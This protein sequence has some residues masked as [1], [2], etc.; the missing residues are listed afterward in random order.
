MFGLLKSLPSLLQKVLFCV[1]FPVS[2]RNTRFLA[3]APLATVMAESYAR[4]KPFDGST[5]FAMWQ[6]KMKA[7]LIKEKCWRAVNE[8]YLPGT[9]DLTKKDL[10]QQAHSEIM[11]RISDEVARQV[12]D[13][14]TAATLWQALQDLFLT[15]SLPN[16]VALLSQ[17]FHYK[18][19]TNN[20]LPE[21]LDRF[22]KLTQ[23]ISRCGEDV[24]DLNKSVLLLNSLPNQ[25]DTFKDVI[26]YGNETLTT[27][28]IIESVTQKNDVLKF[29]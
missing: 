19:N 24:S 20:S 9:T 16:K 1:V 22:L 6:V 17:L 25:F 13:K 4:V 27:K 12:L 3:L 5:D 8:D 7:I 2:N 23:D 14:V 21:N 11:I 28:K 10:D 15:K 26:M 18:M 29:F